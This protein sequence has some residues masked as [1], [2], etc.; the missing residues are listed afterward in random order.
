MSRLFYLELQ[1]ANIE[2]MF[3][4]SK[5]SGL[6]LNLCHPADKVGNDDIKGGKF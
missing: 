4:I 5:Y 1:I 2:L 6:I 3:S